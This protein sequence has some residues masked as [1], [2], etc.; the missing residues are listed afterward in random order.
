MNIALITGS[1][2]R[3]G[4]KI[5]LTFLKKGCH[6]IAVYNRADE[7][8]IESF[9]RYKDIITPL[10]VNISKQSEVNSMIKIIKDRFGRLDYVINSAG[11]SKDSLLIKTQ[12]IEWDEVISV[13]LSGCFYIIKETIPLLINS[14][15]GH[16]VNISS[17]SGLK[18][19]EGQ[20]AYSASK[21]ALIG[22]T[23]SAA[24]ELAGFNIKV[25]A[26]LPGYMET[27]MGMKNLNAFKRAKDTSLLNCLSSPSEVASFIYWLVNTK[28][29][30]GQVFTLDS[31]IT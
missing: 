26:L 19:R 20:A 21:S 11:I 16:I 28:R 14:N 4:T 18:G 24:K 25:N 22:L 31:R 8:F 27:D 13:N 23:Y 10:K 29:I 5:S 1:S 6:V 12:E 17:L 2:G 7:N 30:T 9:E 3:L 15:G